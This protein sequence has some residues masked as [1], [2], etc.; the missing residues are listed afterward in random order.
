MSGFK[1]NC[2]MR[3]LLVE[4]DVDY[5]AVVQGYLRRITAEV[6]V[7]HVTSLAAATALAVAEHFD[8]GVLDL[9]L[10]DSQGTATVTALATAAPHLP[11]VV[12]TGEI[13]SDTDLQALEA[14]AQEYLAKNELGVVPLRRAI[15]YARERH[16][17][18]RALAQAN[19]LNRLVLD[20]MPTNIKLLDAEGRVQFINPA[21]LAALGLSD[22]SAVLGHPWL[23]LWAPSAEPAI[24]AL[25]EQARA[26]QPSTT[27]AFLARAGAAQHCAPRWWHI[28]VLP[29]P[30]N[31]A[32]SARYLVVTQDFTARHFHEKHLHHAQQTAL[33]KHI[34]AGVAHNFNNLLTVVQGYSEMMLRT[35]PEEDARQRRRATDIRQAAIRGRQLVEHLLAYSHFAELS[36]RIIDLN[37]FLEQEVKLLES[38]LNPLASLGFEPSPEPLQVYADPWL[39]S[40]TLLTFVL[41][42]N[43]AMPEGGTVTLSVSRVT[44]DATF[45][46]QP[47][48]DRLVGDV[49]AVLSTGSPVPLVRISVRDTGPGMDAATLANIFTPFFTTKPVDKGTG[50]GLATAAAQVERMGGFIGVTSQP[51]T[52]AQ[53]DVYLPLSSVQPVP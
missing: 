17:L 13:A 10:P 3:I 50:L 52:G 28:T 6:T 32:S 40:S 29:L 19:Q 25:L 24:R 31:N 11:L 30:P 18:T 49:E 9:N 38:T 46:N 27:E 5:A 20:H 15:R 7:R 48:A 22:P 37:A 45:L 33:L 39:L 14:G 16:R 8:V 23:Q 42:A 47:A 12:L 2:T 1:G 51:G 43:E 53:F 36:P 21:G 26:G 4:D 35:L 44:L 41:N 34:A